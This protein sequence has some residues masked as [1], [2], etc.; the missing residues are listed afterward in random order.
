MRTSYHAPT[1][2]LVERTEA[3]PRMETSQHN[4]SSQGE[5]R[6]PTSAS[7]LDQ[8]RSPLLYLN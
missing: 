5:N 6:F 2:R 4:T 3:T 8:F 1:Q 7:I